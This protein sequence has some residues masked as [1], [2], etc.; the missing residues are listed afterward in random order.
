MTGSLFCA[1]GRTFTLPALR[2]WDV[3]RTDGASADAFALQFPLQ[4]EDVGTLR[5]AIRLTLR[6]DR[7]IRFSGLVDEV[8]CTIGPEGWRAVVIGRGLAARLLDNEV[9]GAEF[10]SVGIEDILARYCAP[11]GIIA[12]DRDAALPRLSLFAVPTGCS[13]HQAVWGFC[14]HAANIRPRFLANG[15]LQ[16]RKDPA[17]THHTIDHRSGV[18]QAQWRLCRYGVRTKQT[19]HDLTYGVARTAENPALIAL[20]GR[21]EGVATRSGPY[22]KATEQTA[23]QRIAAGARGLETL[24]IT[25]PGSFLAEPRDRITAVL[26]QWGIEGDF[27]VQQ[28]R[29]RSDLAGLRCTLTLG[30]EE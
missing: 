17:R 28:V 20:G 14:R 30:T 6:E 16:I 9:S 29:S 11:Y 7:E 24:E 18:L 25:L 15:T 4:A 10:Y 12:V 26:P 5:K 3:S 13:C 2:E 19:V 21:S 23:A 1:D 8:E 22:C 27:F